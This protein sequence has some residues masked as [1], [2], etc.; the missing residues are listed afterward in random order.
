MALRWCHSILKIIYITK[1]ISLFKEYLNNFQFIKTGQAF[2]I[3]II[4]DVFPFHISPWRNQ[5]YLEIAAN[6]VWEKNPLDD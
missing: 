4:D 2:D 5:E 6:E 1:K 3:T